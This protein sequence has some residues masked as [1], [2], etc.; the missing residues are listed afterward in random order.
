MRSEKSAYIVSDKH[1]AEYDPTYHQVLCDVFTTGKCDEYLE[2]FLGFAWWP[3]SKTLQGLHYGYFFAFDA[4][5]V[6]QFLT[7]FVAPT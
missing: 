4:V 2:I 6:H 3:T 1:P 5:A 7:S